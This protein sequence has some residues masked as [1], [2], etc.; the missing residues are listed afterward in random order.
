MKINV[1]NF[2]RRKK[3]SQSRYVNIATVLEEAENRGKAHLK[4]TIPF[5]VAE[6]LDQ[7]LKGKGLRESYGIPLLIQYGLSDESEEELERLKSEKDSKLF[8]L[9]T[10]KA[11]MHFQTYQYFMENKSIA[12][13]LN[14]LLSENRSLKKRLENEGLQNYVSKDEWDDWDKSRVEEFYNKYVFMRRRY[15]QVQKKKRDE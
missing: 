1:R 8:R 10:K 4:V 2:F 12:I 13:K 7:F 6:E 11:G 5:K 14:L 3:D 9:E 15:S